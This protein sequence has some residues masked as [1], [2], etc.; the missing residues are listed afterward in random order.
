MDQED[1]N[2]MA[3]E[4]L[5]DLENLELKLLDWK[6]SASKLVEMDDSK[7][8]LMDSVSAVDKFLKDQGYESNVN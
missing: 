7:G 3:W 2:E 8:F 5:G 4:L 6:E 1:M